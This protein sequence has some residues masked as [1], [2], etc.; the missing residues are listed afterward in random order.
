MPE[1]GTSGL[2]SGEGKRTAL[3]IPRLSSTLPTPVCVTG[4]RTAKFIHGA[5]ARDVR[6]V[7]SGVEG[8]CGQAVGRHAPRQ[9]RSC[10][11][12]A[13]GDAAEQIGLGAGSGEGDAHA[14]GG[15]GD[16]CGDLEQSCAV[17]STRRT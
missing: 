5:L 15:L 14:R 4:L 13:E 7:V 17:C 3:A 2:M 12:Q 9:S 1:I 6:S 16:A 11:L 8:C 10:G